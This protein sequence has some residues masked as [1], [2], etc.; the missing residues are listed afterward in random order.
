MRERSDPIIEEDILLMTK[1]TTTTTTSPIKENKLT[2][3]RRITKTSA[4]PKT[5]TVKTTTT[6]ITAKIRTG[7]GDNKTKEMTLGNKRGNSTSIKKTRSTA[8]G[9]PGHLMM[10]MQRGIIE[11]GDQG[12]MTRNFLF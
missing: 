8:Q 10:N 11:E 7:L 12:L 5:T 6:T 3:S 2:M 9:D 1:T 4:A